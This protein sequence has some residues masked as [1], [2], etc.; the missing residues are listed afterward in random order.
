[1]ILGE[2]H[3]SEL[4]LLFCKMGTLTVPA[5]TGTK[6]GTVCNPLGIV[7]NLINPSV[8]VIISGII[9][10]QFQGGTSC[11]SSLWDS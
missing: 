6:G 10:H 1:M 8:L 3:F 9:N 11:R 2:C 4:S 5:L 7:P